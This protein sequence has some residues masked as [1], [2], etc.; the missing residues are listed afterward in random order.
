[1]RFPASPAR[2]AIAAA[3]A[4]K[5]GVASAAGNYDPGASDTEIKIGQTMPYSGPVSAFGITGRAHRAYFDK[6]NAEGGVNGR[7]IKLISL[8]DSFNPSKT[9]EQTRRLVEHEQVLFLF[10]PLGTAPIS[11]IIKYTNAKKVPMIFAS[12]MSPKV[13]D[14]R[15]Y[16]WSIGWL[17][18]GVSEGRV[19]AQYLLGERPNAK[20]AVLYQSDDIGKS[21]L[22]GLDEGY[23]ARA[24]RAIVAR[25][26]YEIADT[27]VDSQVI[28]MRASG[29]DTVVL[30]ATPK[31]AAQAIRKIWDIGWRP[32]RIL[33]TS[34][35]SIDAT[36]K[37]AGLEKS[38]GITQAYFAKDPSDPQWANEPGM[39]EFFAWQRQYFPEAVDDIDQSAYGYN[40]AKALIEVLKRCGDDLTRANVMRQA[41]S[42]RNVAMPLFLDG[43]TLDTSPTDHQ[44]IE[45]L[46]LQRFDG[47][48]WVWFGEVLGK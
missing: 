2:F 46:R 11:A 13:G 33:T 6:V 44:P 34:G 43:I 15:N 30:A 17:P 37:P 8:D 42:L 25:E 47:K 1:M 16:P 3:L 9:V 19:Y 4:C 28:S 31:F 45:R 41:Q 39:K 5:V 14:Y 12:T 32:L 22:E 35:G 7:K 26:S 36:L 23:S 20:V 24:A 48:Q 21:Y 38:V 27:N 18:N 40:A 10:Q 29:A